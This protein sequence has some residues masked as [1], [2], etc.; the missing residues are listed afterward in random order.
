[1]TKKFLTTLV[2]VIMV[3]STISFTTFAE[4]ATLP[5]PDVT[6]GEEKTYTTWSEAITNASDVNGDGVITY[7]VYGQVAVDNRAIKGSAETVNIIGMD[8][9]AELL[10]ETTN[11]GDNG[12]VYVTDDTI[13]YLNFYNIILNRP[14][15][16]WRG[17]EAHANMHFT[18][19]DS[20]GT[21]ALIK[22]TN[23]IFPNGACTNQYGDTTYIDCDFVCGPQNALWICQSTAHASETVVSGCT[24][25]GAKGL[26]VYSEGVTA[27]GAKDD[28]VT[29]L[30]SE[31]NIT[32]KPA[33]VASG[34]GDVT[35]T[36]I[37][38][39]DCPYGVLEIGNTISVKSTV[40]IDGETPT[41]VATCLNKHGETVYVTNEEYAEIV[42]TEAIANGKTSE[43]SVPVAMVSD[44]N[45]SVFYESLQTAI[46]AAATSSSTVNLLADIDLQNIE[47]EPVSFSGNFNGNGH[48]IYNLKINKPDTNNVGFITSVNG[49]FE[50]VNFVNADVV[51]KENVAV[52]AGRAGGSNSTVKN[53]SVTGT[54]KV[55]STNS[56]YARA[57]VIVGGWA[58]GKYI[59]ITVDGEDADTSYVK[60]TGTGDGRYVA[61]IVG[62]ADDV[63]EYTNCI[64]KNIT[65]DG[66]W[67]CGGIAGP[68]PAN[69]T[70][71]DCVVENVKIASD[72]SG[73]MFGWFY[74]AGEGAI[75]NC[76]VKNIEFTDGATKNG[77]IG[78]YSMNEDVVVTN[79]TIENVVNYDGADLLGYCA[80][81]DGEYFSTIQ[82]AIDAAS[83]NDTILVDAGTY[84]AFSIPDDKGGLTIKAADENNKPIISINDVNNGGIQYHAS[85]LTFENLIFN[86]EETCA[87]ATTWNVSALGYYY[88]IV[89]DRNGL[90]V[91]GCDFINN[92]DIEMS[93][94]AANLSEYTVTNC[95]FKNFAT[96]VH[97][98]MDGGILDNVTITNNTYENVEKLVNVYYGGEAAGTSSLTISDNTAIS[99][100]T[101][102][103]IDDYARINNIATTAFDTLTVTNN[104]ATIVLHNYTTD[105]TAVVENNSAKV[106]NYRTEEVLNDLAASAP[107]GLVYVAYDDEENEKK[108]VVRNGVAEVYIP[109]SPSKRP[110]TNKLPATTGSVTDNTDKPEQPADT[111]KTQIILTIGKTEASVFGELKANDVAPKLVNDRTMLPARFVAESLG[112]TV[113]WTETEPNKVLIT[114]DD[115][116]IIIYIGSD[117]A[118]V[119]GEEI[120]LDSPAF[121]ENDR[122]YTPI[123][124]ISEELGADVKWNDELQQV[125]ITKK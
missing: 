78:G 65:I 46:D 116:E 67:L 118:Y 88:E 112:A 119:N 53:I 7:G 51:G 86:I 124:F 109:K 102:I 25:E 81:I 37:D 80:S 106:Y 22:Y 121:L 34:A 41:Y 10:V 45:G 64:V 120:T 55:E 70:A 123:R 111:S 90:W 20:D 29:I 74:T 114:K 122:T 110:I 3:M 16:G 117:K 24:F 63:D 5:E 101:E 50:N 18:V 58:Y 15:G 23:C 28:K 13:E 68:G 39:E 75:D 95:S 8:A 85:D 113:T 91:T 73:G 1:M 33:I 62:H 59:N 108:Y 27:E 42:N 17:N 98:F 36:N 66:D 107:N 96:G 94:I 82:A 56:G 21:T 125:I 43:I 92:S 87:D 48:T 26:K 89:K 83:A 76:T 35:I 84:S 30:D 38:T 61:G 100:T 99:G 71:S 12:L 97:S 72:Y 79:I 103:L 49:T 105:I 6:V 54:I 60:W 19:W 32:D 11:P 93:A 4:D 77:T 14:N 57:G 44:E 52:I 2:A 115:I 31:F 9:T 69:S 47:W 104:D 40:T